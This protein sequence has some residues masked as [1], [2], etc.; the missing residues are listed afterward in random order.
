MSLKAKIEAVIYASEEPVTLQ[1]L[2]GLLGQEAQAELD[3]ADARQGQLALLDTD[4]VVLVQAAEAGDQDALNAETLGIEAI[5]FVGE[6]E[7]EPPTAASA[8][9]ET[10]EAGQEPSSSDGELTEPAIENSGSAEPTPAEVRARERRLREYMRSLLDELIAEYATEERGL[11]IREVAGGFRFATKPEYHDAVRGF[12]R[13]LKPPLKLSLQALE[14]LAVVAYKQP[15]TAPEVSEIRGVDSGGVLGSLMARKLVATAGRKQVIGR[16]IL[17]KTT[18]EFLLRFGLKDL[19]ELPSIEEFERLASDMNEAV[20]EEIPMPP[21]RL[22]E[23][24]PAAEV[25]DAARNVEPMRDEHAAQP[26]GIPDATPDQQG[27][28]E[29]VTPA[30]DGPGE[31]TGDETVPPADNV[32]I[33]GRISG[34]PPSYDQPEMGVDSPALDAEIQGS[35]QRENTGSDDE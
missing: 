1:Q 17:Y 34:V 20:Q 19:S 8:I 23:L 31:F 6:P 29:R 30:P 12:V 33:D 16:P 2:T 18:K 24:K 9:H 14:T 13:S 5:A 3:A 27:D 28:A 25:G 22:D 35:E 11:E 32:E 10:S 21:E 7:G 26:D 15:A 4:G